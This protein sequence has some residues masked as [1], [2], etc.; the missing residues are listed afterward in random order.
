[1]ANGGIDGKTLVTIALPTM[2]GIAAASL[3][4]LRKKYAS[5]VAEADITERPTP[6]TFQ[7]L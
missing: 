3:R 6:P 5:L 4:S 7:T 2:H 1:M